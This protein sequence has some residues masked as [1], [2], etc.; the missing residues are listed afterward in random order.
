MRAGL[1]WLA[2]APRPLP[3][4]AIGA[5]LSMI[6]AT[7]GY[8]WDRVWLDLEIENVLNQRIFEGEY[9]FASDFGRGDASSSI[10]VLHYVAGPPFNARA[11]LAAVF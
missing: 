6:D 2:V 7:V 10:P 3:H 4:G 1:R 8:H 5:P 11:S 9:H